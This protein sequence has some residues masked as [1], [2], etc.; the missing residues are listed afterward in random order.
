MF[1]EGGICGAVSPLGS[2]GNGWLDDAEQ[3][4][5]KNGDFCGVLAA[6]VYVIRSCLYTFESCNESQ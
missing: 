1:E 5:D 6:I 3:C 4:V 2:I